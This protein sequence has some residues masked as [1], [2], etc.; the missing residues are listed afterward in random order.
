MEWGGGEK[1]TQQAGTDS[2]VTERQ[3]NGVLVSLEGQHLQQTELPGA[4]NHRLSR[5]IATEKKWTFS[6]PF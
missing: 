1:E 5:V 3:D 2:Q 4:E 6:Q